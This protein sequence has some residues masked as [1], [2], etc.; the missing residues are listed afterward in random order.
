MKRAGLTTGMY[1]VRRADGRTI[2][3][4]DEYRLAANRREFD[5][6]ATDIF[7]VTREDALARVAT[8]AVF[9]P[10]NARQRQAR[11]EARYGEKPVEK[12]EA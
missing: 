12:E 10:T 1:D 6:D 11:A 4:T 2:L 3:V 8:M 5:P 9:D 7:W